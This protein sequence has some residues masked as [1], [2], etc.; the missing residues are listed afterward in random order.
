[1]DEANI[2]I[3][4]CILILGSAAAFYISSTQSNPT[5]PLIISDN[6]KITEFG[7]IRESGIDL[8]EEYFDSNGRGYYYAWVREN[9]CL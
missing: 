4:I 6:V 8:M 3:I 1:M 5:S 2:F 9:P 7:N